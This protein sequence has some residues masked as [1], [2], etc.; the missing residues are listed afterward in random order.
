MAARS[1][2]R[3]SLHHSQQFRE[4]AHCAAPTPSRWYLVK[5]SLGT[6]SAFGCHLG[7]NKTKCRFKA[8]DAPSQFG[9]LF[10]SSRRDIPTLRLGFARVS[11]LLRVRQTGNSMR[12]RPV[13][14]PRADTARST[15]PGVLAKRDLT[16][17]WFGPVSLD[18]GSVGK[19]RCEPVT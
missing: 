3:P 1:Q 5:Q 18:R 11:E 7:A 17:G 16:A 8:D 2:S 12:C 10:T 6:V 14:S 4:Q 19:A 15:T 9:S 13:W